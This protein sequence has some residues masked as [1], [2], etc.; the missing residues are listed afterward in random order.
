M[1][2]RGI[3]PTPRS[4]TAGPIFR[5]SVRSRRT[6]K[7]S[8]FQCSGA[9]HSGSRARTARVLRPGPASPHPEL[10]L[11]LGQQF[12]VPTELRLPTQDPQQVGPGETAPA[13][14]PAA[15]AGPGRGIA[16]NAVK[17]CSTPDTLEAR[18]RS[19]LERYQARASVMAAVRSSTTAI[20]ILVPQLKGS[21]P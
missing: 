21:T 4:P 13:H 3:R 17:P 8:A 6:E 19:P 20:V 1:L 9:T 16:N 5:P 18:A 11:D 15:P 10:R 2:R 7:T 14:E 12:A